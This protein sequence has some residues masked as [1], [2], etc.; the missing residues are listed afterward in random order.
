MNE[1]VRNVLMGAAGA[2]DDSTFVDDV[3]S[4][5]LYKGN[6]S[7]RS[8]NNGI[9]LSDEGGLVW[10]KSRTAA[11]YDN[12]LQDTVRGRGKYL[13]SNDANAQISPDP[14]QYITSFNANGFSLGTEN[15]INN[16]NNNYFVSWTFR[17]QKGFFDIV[18]YTGNGSNRTIAHSLGSVPGMIIIKNLTDSGEQWAVGHRGIYESSPW[19]YYM[20]L[21]TTNAQMDDSQIFND[22]APT[23][24][25]FS[26]GTQDRVNKNGSNYVAYV[27]AG[28]AS[29]AATAKSV[30]FDGNDALTSA[31]SSDLSF[32]TGDYTVEFW[33]N[34]DAIGDT[35]LFE[36]RVSGSPSDA[37]GFTLTAHGSTNGVRIWWT[38][39]SRING[40]G[41]SLN[42]KQWHHLAATRSS[43]TTYLFL[44]GTLL[45]TTTDSINVTTTEAHIAGGKYSG[46]S[47]LSH[48]FDGKI[49]NFRIVKGTALYTSSFRPTNEPLT[50]VTNTKLLCCNNSSVTGSTVAP[51]SANTYSINV[52]ASGSSAYTLSG[53]DRNGSVSGNN[54]TVTANVGDT[55]NFA[56]NASGHP[57]YIRV[58]NGGYNVSTPAATNQGSQSGTVSWTPNTTGTFYYQCGNHSGMIGTITVNAASGSITS[59]GNP[60]AS[61]DSPFDDPEGFKFGEEGDQNI[62]KC[63][64]YTTD[65]S[66]D[67]NV[68]LGFEPQWVL[69][70]R[71]DSSTGG[72]WLIYDSMRGFLGTAGESG[73]GSLSL[74]PN[75]NSSENNNNRLKITSTGFYADDYG[76]NR[77]YI[78]MALRRPDGYVGKTPELGTDVFAMDTG[79]GSSDIGDPT[80]DSGFPVDFATKKIVA[81][82]NDW[83]TTSRL[84]SGKYLDLNTT[85]AEVS[86]SYDRK[87][88]N[89]GYGNSGNNNSVQSWMWKRHAGFDVQCYTGKTGVQT[90]SHTLNA[91]PE[92]I[93]VKVRNQTYDWCVGHIGLNDGTNP[94]TTKHLRLNN[95]NGEYSENQFT[96]PPTSTHWTTRNGGLVNDNGEKYIAILFAS[97]E[98]ISKVGRYTGNGSTGSSG[99]FI[100]TGF[101]PRFIIVKRV[102]S[103]AG[104]AWNLHDTTRGIDNRLRIQTSAAQATLAAFDLSSTG[105]RV[106]T[107]SGSYN[108]SSGRYVYYAHA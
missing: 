53:N 107:D 36:N 77:S 91:V 15:D 105:F 5:F 90:R 23:S 19:N 35:P 41:S 14:D 21:N 69:V 51:S 67:A 100:T 74:S 80:F 86:G 63:G 27:F 85:D 48:Y 49:S 17:K 61:T 75:N 62:I 64:S 20:W 55:L 9:N 89:L 81:A 54:V 38:G 4:T 56:V 66:E 26:I 72:D 18:T 32:G 30:D 12:I 93:W 11:G 104:Y 1:L 37:T 28:G 3:F 45:G 39:A 6:G 87:D 44:D 31:T 68:Y 94:W 65:S 10:M 50:N 7:A 24:S 101:S 33:F 25:V 99:P 52:T 70:K 73:G 96:T 47:S 42:L 88:S 106:K 58:S 34:A 102:D 13:K 43:G 82:T 79:N 71:I 97:V 76:A 78:Y 108:A 57:F 29:T 59:N 8:I 2:A 46:G 60:T 98:G 83:H 16:G 40:G 22:T 92:M 103:N 95:S 84:T